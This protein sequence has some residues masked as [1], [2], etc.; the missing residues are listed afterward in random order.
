MTSSGRERPIRWGIL[1]TG[2]I[3]GKFTE[4]LLLLPGHSVAAVG[5]RSLASAER[6]AARHGIAR[7][8]GSYA[9]LAA[10]ESLDVVYVAT[11]HPIHHGAARLCLE[12]GRHVLVEKPFTTSVAD[13]EDLV[14]LARERGLFAMEGMWTRFNPLIVRLRELV[15]DGAIGHV[16]AV[17]A[18]FSFAVEFDAEHRL[19]SPDLAGGAL[20]D[21]GVYPLSFAWML[22][23]PPKTVQA[24]ASAA[25]TGVDANTGMLLGY[26]SGAVALL[27]CGLQAE[28][29]QTATVVGTSGRIEVAA[30][31][32]R[33]DTMTVHRDGQEPET[34]TVRPPGHGFTYQ[35]EEVARRLRAGEPESPGMPLEETLAILGTLEHIAELL[36]GDL[37]EPSSARG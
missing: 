13:G 34:L 26:D 10:D 21:V 15:R 22:L 6:F 30:P 35:A 3:A 16:K 14:A 8:Y 5:S 24:T 36:D 1:G 2:W 25:P 33:P 28:S 4:D 12:A 37:A 32:Y 19:W 20:L 23:G 9:E 17:Y 7:A 29:P 27:H 11:P 31:F 18:D